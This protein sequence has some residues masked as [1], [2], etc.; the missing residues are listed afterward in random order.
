MCA[1]ASGSW[2]GRRRADRPAILE[3]EAQLVTRLPWR[4]RSE[5]TSAGLGISVPPNSPAH[6]SPSNTQ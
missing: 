1:V 2:G 3:Q 4:Q 5:L 6:W